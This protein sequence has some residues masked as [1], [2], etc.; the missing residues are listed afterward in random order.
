MKNGVGK[1]ESLGSGRSALGAQDQP[2]A[3]AGVALH[4]TIR[5]R[6]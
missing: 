6:I 2:T 3:V 1:G 4:D 5:G